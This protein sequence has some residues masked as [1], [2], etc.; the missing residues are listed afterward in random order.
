MYIRN[1]MKHILEDTIMSM[2][3]RKV[4]IT[5]KQLNTFNLEK[6]EKKLITQLYAVLPHYIPFHYGEENNRERERER[7]RERQFYQ[8]SVEMKRSIQ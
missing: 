1:Q 4:C 8:H 6:Q 2:R 5:Y 3:S 7:E